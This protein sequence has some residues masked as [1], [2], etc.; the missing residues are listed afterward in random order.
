MNNFK[1]IK[2]LHILLTTTILLFM[3]VILII[4]VHKILKIILYIPYYNEYFNIS[5]TIQLPQSHTTLPNIKPIDRTKLYGALFLD[6]IDNQIINLTNPKI[7]YDSKRL[8]LF[9]Y[10]DV[11]Q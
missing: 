5:K 4:L 6:N 2:Y 9:R 11:V 3:V 10:S 7:Q 1:N 8:Q